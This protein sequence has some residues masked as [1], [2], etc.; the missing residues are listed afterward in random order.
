MIASAVAN[1]YEA[2]ISTIE[3]GGELAAVC[4]GNVSNLL[5]HQWPLNDLAGKRDILLAEAHRDF[6]QLRESYQLDFIDVYGIDPQTSSR[7]VYLCVSSDE[8]IDA[9]IQQELVQRDL[10]IK[11]I[12]EGEQ[13]CWPEPGIFS[14]VCGA[15]SMAKCIP[16]SR[17]IW[18][19][20]ACF[21]RSSA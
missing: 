12:T 21:A 16:G 2:Y 11:Q 1:L 19:E 14:G 9:S 5:N 4:A 20:T 8:E 7:Y 17:R 15:P 13:S 18:T 10:P 6:S 3:R